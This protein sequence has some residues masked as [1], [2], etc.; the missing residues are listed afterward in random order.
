MDRQALYHL[1]SIVLQT[2]AATGAMI[3]MAIILVGL[4]CGALFVRLFVGKARR[5]GD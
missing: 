1:V 2:L 5:R 4:V 3:A